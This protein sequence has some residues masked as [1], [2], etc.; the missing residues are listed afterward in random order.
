MRVE[1]AVA[2][3]TTP[4]TGNGVIRGIE[5]LFTRVHTIVDRLLSSSDSDIQP[6][7]ASLRELE[8]EFPII[9]EPRMNSHNRQL[10]SQMRNPQE[11][12]ESDKMCITSKDRSETMYFTPNV[13]WQFSRLLLMGTPGPASASYLLNVTVTAVL[14][15]IE[16]WAT[17]LLK[18][19]KRH[20]IEDVVGRSRWTSWSI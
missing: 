9:H 14:F 11:L 20:T 1:R 5:Q 17:D 13:N 15:A 8:N 4:R 6:I 16:L 12:C 3:W 10:Q 7:V 18:K 19:P 2:V